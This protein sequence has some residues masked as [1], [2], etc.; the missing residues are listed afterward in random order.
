MTT[1]VAP[2]P[3]IEWLLGSSEPAIRR[4]VRRDLLGEAADDEDVLSGQIVR[5]W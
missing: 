2:A 5:G 1:A 3:V 4:L